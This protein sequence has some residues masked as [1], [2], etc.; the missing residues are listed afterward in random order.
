MIHR[1]FVCSLS[2]LICFFFLAFPLAQFLEIQLQHFIINFKMNGRFCSLPYALVYQNVATIILQLM[3]FNFLEADA[4]DM[5]ACSLIGN[6][7]YDRLFLRVCLDL[8]PDGFNDDEYAA[9]E[10]D[11]SEP[12]LHPFVHQV[13]T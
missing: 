2:F 3:N 1:F 13:G 12:I 10:R 5:V 11:D 4:K 9:F 6:G 8:L 7:C